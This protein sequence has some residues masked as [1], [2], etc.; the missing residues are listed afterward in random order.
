MDHT[1]NKMDTFGPFMLVKT[2]LTQNDNFRYTQGLFLQFCPVKMKNKIRIRSPQQSYVILCCQII[3]ISYS[4]TF[5][6]INSFNILSHHIYILFGRIELV[7]PCS[8]TTT[9]FDYEQISP[10]KYYSFKKNQLVNIYIKIK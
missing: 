6:P 8:M 5:L 9:S 2:C 4:W 10:S 3:Y 1:R 7:F